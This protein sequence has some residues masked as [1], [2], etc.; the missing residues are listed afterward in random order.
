M[1]E[2]IERFQP[3][4]VLDVGCGTGSM[5]TVPLARKYPHIQF[6]G[7][8]MDSESIRFAKSNHTLHNL[9]FR[10]LSNMDTKEQHDFII[11]TEVIEHVDDPW[12]FLQFLGGILTP[13]GRLIVTLPNGYGPFE[14]MSMA[15]ALLNIV[16]VIPLLRLFKRLAMN[17]ARPV[18]KAGADTLAESPHINFFSFG[19]I[20]QLFKEGGFEIR[21]Y[22]P[23]TFL[24][25][26]GFDQ[27]LRSERILEWNQKIADILPPFFSSDWMF[28]LEKGESMNPQVY[29]RG[30]LSTLRKMLNTRCRSSHSS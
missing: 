18:G 3:K 13:K 19:Q 4:R 11:A 2:K 22:Q 8:D 29:K 26:F 14:M 12:E 20:R 10:E 1:Q 21:Q 16:G 25:G 7:I 17:G 24:C 30:P 27:V 15:E 5:V 6:L 23:R 28:L 9:A